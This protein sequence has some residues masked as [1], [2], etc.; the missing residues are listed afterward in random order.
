MARKSAESLAVVPVTDLPSRMNPPEF[1][2]LKEAEVWRAVVATKPLDWFQADSAP[3]LTEYC[4][5]VV[6]CNRLADMIEVASPEDLHNLLIDRDREA[7]RVAQLAVKMRLTQQS[8]YT[9]MASATAAK[10]PSAGK[11]WDFGRSG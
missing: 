5:A 2:P 7:K 8:R 1:L 3:I 6:M 4:R 9:P 10:A 11:V